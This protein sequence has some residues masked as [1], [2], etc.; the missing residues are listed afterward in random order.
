MCSLL[1]LAELN[2]KKI[3]PQGTIGLIGGGGATPTP[4][5]VVQLLPGQ[6]S[7]Q[8]VLSVATLT[9]TVIVPPP[10]P[11]VS[12]DTSDPLV[13]ERVPPVVDQ[14]DWHW[15]QVV[16]S[17]PPDFA[18]DDQS[19]GFER[20]QVLHDPEARHAV[21][22][23]HKLALTGDHTVTSMQQVTSRS[24][25]CEYAGVIDTWHSQQLPGSK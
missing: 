11:V 3:G 17:L 22:R 14:L 4:T 10:A 5:V 12:S 7:P 9:V 13:D 1:I 2:G 8:W 18:S 16:Q 24:P 21:H 6:A 23:G 15:I 25:D 20:A 19:R